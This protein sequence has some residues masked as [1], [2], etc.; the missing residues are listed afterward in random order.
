MSGTVSDPGTRKRCR[1]PSYMITKAKLGRNDGRFLT[2]NTSRK[3]R[4][5]EEKG[6]INRQLST[7][8]DNISSLSSYKTN[9]IQLI[10]TNDADLNGMFY[11]IL[12]SSTVFFY[13]LSTCVATGG[14][15]ATYEDQVG[16]ASLDKVVIYV[17]GER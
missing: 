8:Y 15:G 1:N 10:K 13:N 14:A 4:K 9:D 5:V 11:F 7:Y 12:N 3:T 17:C 16:G 2:I 6:N